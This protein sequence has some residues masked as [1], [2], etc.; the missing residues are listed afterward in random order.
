MRQV[1]VSA[2]TNGQDKRRL[3]TPLSVFRCPSD[4]TGE[5]L[6]DSAADKYFDG[7]RLYP[8]TSNYI[9][10]C[11]FFDVTARRNNGVL[12]MNGDVSMRD[13][14][15]GSSN[16]FAVGERA[17]PCG[18]GTWAGNRNAG[19]GGYRGAD[20]TTGV[21][22]RRLNE[23]AP[24]SFSSG[25]QCA[26]G[27]SSLHTGGAHFLMCDGAVRFVSE[28]INWSNGGATYTNSE[29]PAGTL[30]DTQKAALGT[31][32]RLGIRNDEQ[33]VGEF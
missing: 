10:V 12:F 27:F 24:S 31:Y 3:Q 1:V 15:D 28:N 9:G 5:T 23:P 26:D 18:A 11:G 17:A 7:G 32:Q 22:S 13:I 30:T 19:G 16:T 21:I 8:S 25:A 4:T 33:T 6:K 20:Y 2:R 14:T 29:D